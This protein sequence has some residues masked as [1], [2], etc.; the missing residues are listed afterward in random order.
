[1]KRKTLKKCSR[2]RRKRT[3]HRRGGGLRDWFRPK[4][5]PTDKGRKDELVSNSKWEV[6]Y[7][8]EI[9]QKK[10]D[11]ETEKMDLENKKQSLQTEIMGYKRFK[12]QNLQ[13]SAEEDR[14]PVYPEGRYAY[15]LKK[16]ESDLEDINRKLEFLEP[17]I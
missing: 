3:F 7:L 8:N 10:R 16:A 4:Q 12:D 5:R 11:F 1:M 13:S 2:R 14:D 6:Q 15:E 9:K 17:L